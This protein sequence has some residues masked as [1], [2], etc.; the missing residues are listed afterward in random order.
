MLFDRLK[1]AKQF[2]D[3]MKAIGEYHKANDRNCHE[4]VASKEITVVCRQGCSFCCNLKVDVRPYEVFFIVKYIAEHFSPEKRTKIVTALKNHVLHLSK[5]T[6]NDHLSTNAPCPFLF[7]DICSVYPARPFACRAY[8]SLDASSCQY[9]FENPADLKEKRATDPDLDLQWADV[10][11][12][13]A[14]IFQQLGY[15]TTYNEIGTVLL[16]SLLDSKFQKRW[17]NKKKAFVGIRTYQD[18]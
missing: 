6:K 1:S 7:G 4:Y 18:D 16:C 10:R 12:A 13:V 5:I 11:T 15:D 14:A 17:M 2:S 3:I 9:S 8:Y